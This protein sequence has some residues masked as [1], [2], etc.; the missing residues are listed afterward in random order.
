MEDQV[1]SSHWQRNLSD[2]SWSLPT[3]ESGA[4]AGIGAHVP[5]TF[6]RWA[7]HTAMQAPFRR[8]GRSFDSFGPTL[9]IANRFAQVDRRV[10]DIDSLRQVLTLSCVR[11]TLKWTDTDRTVLVIGDGYARLTSL[12]LATLQRTRVVL[13]N[14]A[15][16]LAV[17]LASLER[18]EQFFPDWRQ[19]V[20]PIAAEEKDRLRGVALDAAVNTSSMQEMHPDEIARYFA[21]LRCNVNRVWFYCANA[22]EK[23]LPDGTPVR[24]S[25]YPW[26]PDDEIVL[27]GVCPWAQANYT[28]WPPRYLKRLHHIAHRLARL[29]P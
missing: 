14:L 18:L 15:P 27:D 26:Q 25:E 24:F 9:R 20:Q 10:V 17:D 1:V 2:P 28:I 3:S 19:R 11:S 12:I 13:V 8:M 22:T 29:A 7:L 4:R 5:Y 6:R 16:A 21:L 23:R